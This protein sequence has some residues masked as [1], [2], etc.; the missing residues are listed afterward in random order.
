MNLQVIKNR[1]KKIFAYTVTSVLFLIIAGF[2]ILQMPPVQNRIIRFYLKDFSEVTGFRSTIDGFKMLWFDRL[3]L[4]GVSIYDPAGNKMI[5]AGEIMIN[6]E[7]SHLLRQKNVNVDGIYLDSAHVY[8]AMLDESDTSR[9]LNI[10]IL[11]ARINEKFAGSGGGGKTP[12]INIGEAFLNK[13]QFTYYNQFKDSIRTGFNYNQFSVAVDEAQLE[14]FMIMGDTT[15]FNVRTLIA[16]DI[17]TGFPVT[18]LST[19]FRLS[20]GGMEFTGL[21]LRAGES[22][23]RDTIIFTYARQRDLNNFISKVKIHANLSNSIVNHKDLSLFAPGVERLGKPVHIS[24]RIDGKVNKF[25]VQDMDVLLGNTRFKGTLDMDGLPEVTE[26]F[27]LL[28]VADSQLD[29]EDLSFLL[30]NDVLESLRPMGKLH[31]DGQF[32]G[33]P[34]DFVANGVLIGKLGTIRS[35]INFK[36]N[37]KDFNLS[38]YSGKLALSKFSLGR[39]LN[40]T[41]TFQSVSLD[42]QISGSGLTEKTADFKLNGSVAYIGINDYN[43]RNITTN[44]RF[45]AGLFNGY[46]EI[47]DPNLEFQAQGSVDIRNGANRIV[48]DAKLDTA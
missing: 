37:E 12:R 24:G 15:E 4:S 23:I 46:V 36:V 7:L 45:A 41:A 16:N 18:Q 27:I 22:Y 34:T 17:A 10:N 5:R 28:N 14:G 26:T 9:D 44:A 1:I 21:D 19:F 11:I 3:E 47:N 13:S 48:L 35:D 38:E 42:G 25:K 40:D 29:P 31:V 20:Q 43:Y 8:L 39:Y 6:F 2:L 32:L 33:Y 30:S